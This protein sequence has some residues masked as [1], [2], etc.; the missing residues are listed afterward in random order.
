MTELQ[1]LNLANTNA[2]GD[3]ASLLGLALLR[4]LFLDGTRAYG[5]AAALRSAMGRPGWGGFTACSDY[6]SC[7]AGTVAGGDDD[8]GSDECA[9]CAGTALAREPAT[10]VCACPAG[11][12]LGDATVIAIT[13]ADCADC[14]AGTYAD[15]AGTVAD[16]IDCNIGKYS[17]TIGSD[18][19]T[20]CADCIAGKYST[21]VGSDIA[22][23]CLDCDAGKY[24]GD[25]ASDEPT[26]CRA[27]VAL[28]EFPEPLSQCREAVTAANPLALSVAADKALCDAAAD[29]DACLG[30]L[31]TSTADAGTTTACV[32]VPDWRPCSV[33]ACDLLVCD[34]GTTLISNSTDYYYSPYTG[35][36]GTKQQA[37]CCLPSCADDPSGR[38]ACEAET[39][40]Y[41]TDPTAQLDPF[42]D[43]VCN[44]C[45]AGTTAEP[46]ATECAA[47]ATCTAG[48][49]LLD[50]GDCVDCPTPSRCL[51]DKSCAAGSV[52][53]ACGN[54]SEEHL[55]FPFST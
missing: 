40:S 29:G 36:G 47:T 53:I 50:S 2:H 19:A 49:F 31:T 8:A 27:L 3:I 38:C 7:P 9:C 33:S 34:P 28:E 20:D 54:Y 42:T 37:A 35:G 52:G 18:T 1:R 44:A 30:P 24:T 22:T 32:Y 11:K 45:P 10:D 46:F 5:D 21:T 39:E 12:Y 26:D 13:I 17:D 4:L 41:A 23:D 51:G 6:G 48:T 43:A 16:C 14:A 55:N 15:V 25:S